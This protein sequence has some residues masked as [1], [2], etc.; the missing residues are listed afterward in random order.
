MRTSHDLDLIQKRHYV[1]IFLFSLATLLL[2]LSLTRV[3]SV[4]LW[5]HFGFLIISTA[6]LGFGASG[7]A[8][9]LW[10]R[11]REA[12]DL[13]QALPVL[14]MLF[15]LS[16]IICFWLMQRIPFDP[17][18]VLSDR[19]QLVFMPLYYLVIATPFFCSGLH[20]GSIRTREEVIDH[21]ASGGRTIREG[22]YKGVG[23]T[24]PLRSAFV[25]G[26][27]LTAQEKRDLIAFLRSLTD[28]TFLR[29][30]RYSNPWLPEKATAAGTRREDQ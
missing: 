1:G 28:E 12:V 14:A 6:L 21:Y 23:S 30:P 8:L 11:L 27:T 2:E 5:Y 26:F 29:N 19:R 10:R 22:E 20:D 13:D 24:S 15:G 17:F 4:A 25:K 16:T 18:R 9:A 7:V 3:L